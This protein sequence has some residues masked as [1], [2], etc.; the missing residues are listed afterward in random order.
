[1][2]SFRRHTSSRKSAFDCLRLRHL[3]GQVLG[4]RVVGDGVDDLER[5]LRAARQQGADALGHRLAEG[6]VDVHEHRGARHGVGG[7]EQLADQRQAVA[8]DVG[9][10]L[11]VAEYELVALLGDL[12]RG[13][14]VDHE[15]HAALLGD[16]GDRG[17]GAGVER[18]DQHVGAF[19]DQALGA[20]A[21][22]VDVGLEVGVHQLDVD[23]E[24]L[25]DHARRE[26]GALLARL[27]DEAEVARARQD[28]ADLQLLRLRADD[29]E[30]RKR[31]SGADYRNV[32]AE[33]S[34]IH[35]PLL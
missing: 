18:A 10:G 30:R 31:R 27:A 23:A 14:D 2:A 34:A 26:V 7:L 25:L 8:H 12:R 33:C 28:H 15:R 16:L 9:R 13:R 4:R 1:M 17:G 20:G 29:A 3:D 6:V 11:E 19:L 5:Q 32:S 21:R 22:G 24:H 35:D